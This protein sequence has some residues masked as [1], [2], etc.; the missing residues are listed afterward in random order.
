[1]SLLESFYQLRNAAESAGGANYV[2]RK[3]SG[4][5][6]LSKEIVGALQVLSD[7]GSLPSLSINGRI[8]TVTDLPPSGRVSFEATAP[9]GYFEDLSELIRRH[10]FDPPK[11][12]RVFDLDDVS[13]GLPKYQDAV[14]LADLLTA[15]SISHN[16]AGWT[17]WSK[18][19]LEIPVNYL[20]DDLCTINE[21]RNMR[22]KLIDGPNLDAQSRRI[23]DVYRAIFVQAINDVLVGVPSG[24][25]FAHLM[26]HFSEC[27]F[28]FRLGFQS[29]SDEA[30][31]A[32]RRYEESRAGMIT[33]LNGV[34]GNIQTAL[35]G[36]P[37]AGLLALK[38]MKPTDGI[39]YENGI[40]AAAVFIVGLLLLALSISQE[41]TLKAIKGQ[42]KQLAAE[43][44]ACGGG[45]SKTGSLIS[46]MV[47]H[48]SLVST[49]L[50]AVRIIIAVF[51]GVALFALLY[52][53]RGVA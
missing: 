47:K 24:R 46:E 38:E 31:H 3:L 40:I 21:V 30:N 52:R 20:A 6:D 33:A 50:I 49:L 22:D 42:H 27:L 51:M 41:K 23:L 2:E 28:R 32:I 11:D 39:T 8:T 19:R 15:V 43:I 35:I 44:E 9:K 18:D 13:V 26:G 1:M 36:V 37:L 25:R 17:L 53:T 12:L 48:H 4:E 45:E 10:P 14:C 7:A 29:F 16:R 5:V 34:L